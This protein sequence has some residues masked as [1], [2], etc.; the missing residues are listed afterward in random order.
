MMTGAPSPDRAEPVREN[1]ISVRLKSPTLGLESLLAVATF[2]VLAL[3]PAAVGGYLIYILPQ[4]MMYGLLAMSLGLIWGFAG[5]VSFGQAAFFAIGGY[6]LGLSLNGNWGGDFFNPAYT[7]LALCLLLGG[8]LALVTGFFL[9]SA[10][11]RGAYFV[12][13]T[14]ALSIITEQVAV[15]QSHITGGWNGLFVPRID[16]T[17]GPLGTLSLQKDVPFYYFG[18]LVTA[19]TYI[20]LRWLMA[21]KFGKVL[22]SIRENEDRTLALGYNTGLYKTFAF[23]TSAAVASLAGAL[24]ATNASFIAPTLAGVFFSTEVVVWVAIAGRNSLLAALLG[25]ILVSYL[26]N[27]ASTISPQYWQL[28]LAVLFIAVIAYFRGGVAGI[29]AQFPLHRR[30]A[31][32]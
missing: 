14:I 16:L 26:S 7:G 27:Y 25:G 31:T 13:L 30:K 24:Y 18:L 5:I 2:S 22:K 8:S 29:L 1:H 12:L 10:G 6:V 17:F 15:T 32:E 11:V 21:A 4:Y 19:A 28:A 23:G 3:I 20:L 9:F